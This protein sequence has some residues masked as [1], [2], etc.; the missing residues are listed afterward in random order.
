MS[1]L[2][3]A[4]NMAIRPASLPMDRSLLMAACAKSTPIEI[5]CD[6]RWPQSQAGR[7][8]KATIASNLSVRLLC[9]AGLTLWP[10]QRYCGPLFHAPSELRLVVAAKMRPSTFHKNPESGGPLGFTHASCSW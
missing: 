9:E 5:A 10:S 8:D 1:K 7:E 2:E 3:F 4:P 6:G